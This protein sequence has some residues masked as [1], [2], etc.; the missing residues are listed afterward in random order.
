MHRRGKYAA[1]FTILNE[2]PGRKAQLDDTLGG[3][4]LPLPSCF[5]WTYDFQPL[6]RVQS[7]FAPS[8]IEARCLC[9]LS[10]AC[11]S[12]DLLSILE[13]H[14]CL[15]VGFELLSPLVE[16]SCIVLSNRCPCS[17]SPCYSLYITPP[18][19]SG[20]WGNVFTGPFLLQNDFQTLYS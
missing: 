20:S 9:A 3:G 17:S 4:N 19:A 2:P 6:G 14:H 12:K 5:L 16:C 8:C 7:L 11:P 15:P 18:S 10:S 1:N 13:E